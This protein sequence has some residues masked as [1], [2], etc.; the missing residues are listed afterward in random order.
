MY[1]DTS[2]FKSY[3]EMAGIDLIDKD[4]TFSRVDI[5]KFKRNKTD[6][7]LWFTNSKFKDQE[8]KWDSPWGFGYPSWHL[9][10]AAMNLE[11]FK[12]TLDIHLGGVDHIGVH[13]IN[14]IA[15]VECF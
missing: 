1:F 14:E 10:C 12:D 7:V 11:Y 8:M 9:E 5:D 13:H 3:G 4:M 15:I 2:C 6:F